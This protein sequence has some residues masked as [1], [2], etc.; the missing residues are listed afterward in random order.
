MNKSTVHWQTQSI[1]HAILHF[2]YTFSVMRVHHLIRQPSERLL[3]PAIHFHLALIYPFPLHFQSNIQNYPIVFGNSPKFHQLQLVI[4]HY[5]QFFLIKEPSVEV[6]VCQ[7]PF[8]FWGFV[9]TLANNVNA[10]DFPFELPQTNA[11]LH[12]LYPNP[13]NDSHTIV[14]KT[15]LQH[16]E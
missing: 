14:S 11:K 7:Y 6:Y 1:L 13:R 10:V 3:T 15:Q 12:Y 4:L 5:Y 2:V 9:A 8:F 16:K